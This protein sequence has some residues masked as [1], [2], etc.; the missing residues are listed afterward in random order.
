GCISEYKQTIGVGSVYWRE[1]KY[2]SPGRNHSIRYSPRPCDSLNKAPE[3]ISRRGVAHQSDSGVSL[4]A[5]EYGNN[6]CK[7]TRR[8]I[9]SK[10]HINLMKT[11]RRH[12]DLRGLHIDKRDSEIEFSLESIVRPAR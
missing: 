10:V 1:G 2:L 5:S 6:P 8:D 4:A 7:S 11:L 12:F 9:R 3:E